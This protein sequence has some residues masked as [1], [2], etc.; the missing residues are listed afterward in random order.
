VSGVAAGLALSIGRNV[1]LRAITLV[2]LGNTVV[3]VVSLL[4][5]GARNPNAFG[6]AANVV[7][8]A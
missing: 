5:A 4:V 3:G 1:S 2:A 7:V 6:L 8:G